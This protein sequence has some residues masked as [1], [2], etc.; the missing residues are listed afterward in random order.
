MP[1][2]IQ[3][4]ILVLAPTPLVAALFI[5]FGRITARLGAQYSRLSPKLYYAY[6]RGKD[7]PFRKPDAAVYTEA[8]SP[9]IRHPLDRSM[10]MLIAGVLISTVLIYIRSVYRI[11]EFIDGFNGTI[12]HTQV[13]FDVFDGML[14]TLAMYTLN[15]MHPGILL[16]ATVAEGAYALTDRSR[17]SL[18]RRMSPT[19]QAYIVP[20]GGKK[21]LG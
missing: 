17:T 15:A 6:R 9:S 21:Y 5:G 20:A 16:S 10:K 18:D 8:A 3:V 19:V 13:L 11:I 1:Y 4:S 12:A 14:V 7:R 2:I